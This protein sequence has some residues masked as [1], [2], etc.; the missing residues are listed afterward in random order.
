LISEQG[1]APALCE[2]YPREIKELTIPFFKVE[3]PPLAGKQ[4]YDFRSKEITQS[5]NL[6]FLKRKINPYWFFNNTVFLLLL[7]QSTT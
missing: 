1:L 5:P 3:D 2:A 6:S 4:A 7:R